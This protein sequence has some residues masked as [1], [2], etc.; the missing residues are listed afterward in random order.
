MKSLWPVVMAIVLAAGLCAF[1]VAIYSLGSAV[2]GVLEAIIL[3]IPGFLYNLPSNALAVV[4]WIR[5]LCWTL[6]TNPLRTI[7]V[8]VGML[9]VVTYFRGIAGS[10]NA[11]SPTFRGSTV[12]S[13][14]QVFPDFDDDFR[15]GES[16]VRGSELTNYESLFEKTNRPLWRISWNKLKELFT[17]RFDGDD[18]L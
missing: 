10:F 18:L 17:R 13:A 5:D 16:R 11:P 6:V 3:A 2:G 9:L 7:C 15:R 14:E 12:R 1:A 4:C 8:I